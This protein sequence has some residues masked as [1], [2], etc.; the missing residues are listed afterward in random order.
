M[1]PKTLLI[2][3][4][5]TGMDGALAPPT[6]GFNAQDSVEAAAL[7]FSHALDD[8]SLKTQC[9]QGLEGTD[10]RTDETLPPLKSEKIDEDSFELTDEPLP[11]IED[12]AGGNVQHAT[13]VLRL[14]RSI[15]SLD[16]NGNRQIVFYQSGVGSES[17]FKGDQITGTTAMQALGT[18]VASKIRDAYVF[19]A[20]NFD[21]GD[22]ICLFGGAYTARKLAGLIDR[23]GLLTR[24]RLGF[25]FEIWL[26]LVDDKTPHIPPDTRRP[27]I[28]CV[29]VWDTVG[30]VYKEI[31]ALN[32]V[33][34]DLPKTVK[35]A[36]HAISLQENRKKFL[37]TLWTI[38]EGG[39]ED[40]QVW[41]AGAHSDVG[42]GYE[43]HELADISLYW[44]TGE[45]TSLIDIDLEF[46]RTFAQVQPDPWG[47]SQP[48]NAYKETSVALRPI[49]GHETR[50]ESNQI[51]QQSIFHESVRH[52]PQ[53][54]TSPDYMITMSIIQNTFGSGFE[55]QYLA[56]NEFEQYCR[57]HWGRGLTISHGVESPGS[58]IRS[59]AHWVGCSF[60]LCAF[61]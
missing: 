45:L 54:L 22:E 42:G 23:I 11:G 18:A 53:Q 43:R 27:A 52:S 55:P 26:E 32:I 61:C 2:F 44:M 38:P 14:S 6:S 41:F 3:C 59:T 8:S 39:L 31:N 7:Q 33:D 10:I 17:T 21:D 60:R 15:K 25:F 9:L 19:I 50:L 29:G 24:E 56:L 5:G 47:T 37:P 40:N 1:A 35:V 51:V 16:A 49:I 12:V 36:L 20:Q 48:H 28:K 30:S 34:T 58:V 4:D 57:D 46:L 13:N